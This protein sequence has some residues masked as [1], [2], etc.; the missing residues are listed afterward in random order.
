MTKWRDAARRPA[1]RSNNASRHSGKPSEDDGR[2]REDS[3]AD[4]PRTPRAPGEGK[5]GEQ[6][7]HRPLMPVGHE[8][9]EGGRA[10][11]QALK[12]AQVHAL[13]PTHHGRIAV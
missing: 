7:A 4:N 6:A 3:A 2:P 5:L 1:L 12:R 11:D 9:L 8:T 13:Q 10:Q